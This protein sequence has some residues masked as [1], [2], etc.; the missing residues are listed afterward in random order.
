MTRA[1]NVEEGFSGNSGGEVPQGNGNQQG[2]YSSLLGARGSGR[3]GGGRTGA[4]QGGSLRQMGGVGMLQRHAS[5]IGLS[6]D[7][8]DSLD[9]L[10]TRHELEKIDL[11]AALQKAKV[12]QRAKARDLSAP[13][14]EVMSAIEETC[15]AECELRKMRYRHL[16]AAHGVLNQD[17]LEKVRR[18][19]RRQSQDRLEALRSGRGGNRAT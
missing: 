12:L 2:P 13:E 5:E 4:Q 6:D 15:R 1:N 7:Q 18:F 9:A 17:Q 14:A 19:H 11:Q 16:K 3:G 8:L 10:R